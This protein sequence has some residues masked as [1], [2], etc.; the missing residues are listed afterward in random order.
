VKE[1]RRRVSCEL[2]RVLVCVCLFRA[3]IDPFFYSNLPFIDSSPA[4]YLPH[5][6]K[7]LAR[8]APFSR[9]LYHG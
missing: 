8:R 7:N 3:K 9:H 5:F 4:V 1:K 2:G 6:T